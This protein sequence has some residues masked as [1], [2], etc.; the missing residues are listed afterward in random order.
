MRCSIWQLS[1]FNYTYK[2]IAKPS[3]KQ[4]WKACSEW[5]CWKVATE[6]YLCSLSVID[7]EIT[8]NCEKVEVICNHFAKCFSNFLISCWCSLK[9]RRLPFSHCMLD[10]TKAMQWSR[11]HLHCM[12]LHAQ[13]Y[14]ISKQLLYESS[15]HPCM[16]AQD[17]LQ[18]LCGQHYR[19]GG[20]S[21]LWWLIT[22]L[23]IPFS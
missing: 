6:R 17:V 22:L 15:F 1:E 9:W 7:Q 3:L 19:Q 10:I 4:F 21:L 13:S 2:E 14:S 16:V 8:P 23:D 18:F 12:N 5:G 20:L 11:W